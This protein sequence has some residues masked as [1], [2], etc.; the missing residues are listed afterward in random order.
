MAGSGG[1][2][3]KHWTDE[4]LRRLR[5]LAEQGISA[6]EAAVRLH[7]STGAVQQKAIE[8]G[9]ALTRVDRTGWR[10]RSD[11]ARDTSPNEEDRGGFQQA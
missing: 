6:P 11:M 7:R 9:I 4:E 5:Q 1:G 3:H 8:I 2:P 10:A